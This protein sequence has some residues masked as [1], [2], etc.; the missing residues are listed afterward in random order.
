MHT[1][2]TIQFYKFCSDADMVVAETPLGRWN[3]FWYG[4]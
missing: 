4:E 1:L 3:N 2:N